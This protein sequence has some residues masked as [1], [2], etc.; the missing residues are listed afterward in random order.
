[1]DA[2]PAY[3][4]WIGH[5][6]IGDEAI[7]RAVRTLLSTPRPS[8]VEYVDDSDV[9]IYGGGTIFPSAIS[10]DTTYRD[11][12]FTAAIGVGT[13]DP[14]FWNQRFSPLDVGYYTGRAV[15]SNALEVEAVDDVLHRATRFFDSFWKYN[16]TLTKRDFQ[17]VRDA[18]IDFLGVRG[19]LS[20]R[21]LAEYDV[22]HEV[23]GDTALVLEPSADTESATPRIAVT[24]R[25][26]TYGWASNEYHETVLEFCRHHAD[27]YEF[28]FLPFWPPD[29]DICLDAARAVPGARFVDYCSQVDVQ[30]VLDDIAGCDLLIGDKLHANVL[31][32]CSN[33]PFLSL[34]YRTKNRDFAESVGM[35]QFNVRTDEV[36]EEWLHDRLQRIEES[37]R[38]TDHLRANVNSY[39]ESLRDFTRRI[40]AGI[41]SL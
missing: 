10:R 19:P 7:Y 28:V 37:N 1:M 6:N 41:E 4:G 22:D 9:I 14:A 20:S 16:K 40:A 25:D 33:T 11:E 12:A 35:G 5:R 32:A 23:V 18:D 2:P 8:D 39:R 29:I 24:L 38:L 13:R 17:A 21:M 3:S 31:S 30:G 36:T 26:N 15:N 27:R 34:E